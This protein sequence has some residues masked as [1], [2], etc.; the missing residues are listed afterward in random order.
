MTNT[1]VL[2]FSNVSFQAGGKTLLDNINLSVSQGE[3][4]GVLGPNGAGK[5]TLLSLINA[6]QKPTDGR[7]SIFGTDLMSLRQLEI[8]E[9]R[10]RIA[11]V[12]QSAE[13][14]PVVPLT[15]LEVVEIA[16][17]GQRGLLKPLSASDHEIAHSALEQLGIAS[18]AKRTYRSLSGGERQKVQLARALAQKPDLLLLDEPTTGLDMDWQERLIALIEKL[19]LEMRITIVMTTHIT[20]HLPA[21]CG[22]VILLRAGRILFDAETADALTSERLGE[23]Y[24]CNVEVVF[25]SG[26]LHCFGA[27]S[28]E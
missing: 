26:R 1:D 15:A 10:R 19:F 25:R 21:C 22:R 24:S 4:L 2:N 5:T 6:M 7:A 3:F 14:N 11:V 12:L 17:S 18:L 9:L 16:R 23:L 28:G 13:F 20:G 8:L 27:G